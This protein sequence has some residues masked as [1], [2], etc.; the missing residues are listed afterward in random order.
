MHETLNMPN[1][2]DLLGNLI[3]ILGALGVCI[4]AVSFLVR[5]TIGV[6]KRLPRAPWRVIWRIVVCLISTAL[7][8]SAGYFFWPMGIAAAV[9]GGLVM[10]GGCCAVIAY[11]TTGNKQQS[12]PFVMILCGALVY[13]GTAHAKSLQPDPEPKPT[14]PSNAVFTVTETVDGDGDSYFLVK[15]T[16]GEWESADVCRSTDWADD[17]RDSLTDEYLEAHP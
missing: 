15:L 11:Y 4:L 5:G 9:V 12:W 10:L 8:G 3:V 14:L 17:C 7:V 16:V 6:C 13:C 2:G 1:F